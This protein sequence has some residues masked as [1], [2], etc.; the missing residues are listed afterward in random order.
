[1]AIKLTTT[2]Q[3]TT[4]VKCLSFGNAGIGKTTMCKTAP[5]PI[6]ICAERGLL[7]LSDVDIPVI[8]VSSVDDV[9]DAFKFVTESKDAEGFETVCLDSISDIAETLLARLKEGSTDPRQAYGKL[10]DMMMDIVKKF[11][12]IEGK[13]VYFTAKSKRVEDQFTGITSWIPSMPG[14]TLGPALPYLFDFVLPLRIGRTDDNKEFRYLQT[15]A[16]IQYEAKDRSGKLDF[17]E[18]PNLAKLF[19]KALDPETK[20]K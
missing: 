5:N 17:M 11:R 10:N 2:A 8:E 3:A 15:V 7:S 20:R 19:A 18:E 16:D 1:M 4:H 14:Q 12:D 13:H 6:I 9:V